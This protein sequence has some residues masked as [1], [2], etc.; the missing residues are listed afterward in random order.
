MCDLCYVCSRENN[1]I[2][3][4]GGSYKRKRKQPSNLLTCSSCVCSATECE[5]CVCMVCIYVNACLYS[6]YSMHC[7]SGPEC[8]GLDTVYFPLLFFTAPGSFRK[9]EASGMT[10][11]STGISWLE[12]EMIVCCRIRVSHQW[13]DLLPELD[14]YRSASPL[15]RWA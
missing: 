12:V 4:S 1:Q 11:V 15:W 6:K 7:S 9:M 10:T 14:N 2:R 5:S 3:H 13:I 8:L